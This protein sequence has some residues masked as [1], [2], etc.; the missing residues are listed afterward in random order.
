MIEAA[1]RESSSAV[2]LNNTTDF[3]RVISE[4]PTLFSRGAG[5]AIRADEMYCP[6]CGGLRK[7]FI[8]PLYTP[9]RDKPGAE[10]LNL[11]AEV[12]SQLVPS[13]FSLACVQCDTKFTLVVYEGPDGPA[14]AILQSCRGGLTTPHTPVGV[15][16]YLDQAHRAQSVGANSA[17]IAMFRGALEH[18]LFEQGYKIG[19]LNSKIDQ[20]DKDS[21]TAKGPQWA[22]DL[23]TDFLGVLQDLG[24]GSIH[25][26]DGDVTKQAALDN[27]LVARVQQTFLL[28]LFLVY[29]VP[30]TKA[31]MLAELKAK[32]Q[33]LKK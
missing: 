7:M 1:R 19:M 31:G 33:T 23:E 6:V 32:A 5:G 9:P 11:A 30:H 21:A 22:R 16:F 28:L 27:G 3:A 2:M 4:H 25:P 29:E 26:N 10:G 8:R 20:L 24:N 14:L 17:A 15:A 12:I 13:L 18:L